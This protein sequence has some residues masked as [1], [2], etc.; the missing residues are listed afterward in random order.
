M[1]RLNRRSF[2]QLAGA[3]SISS[4]A[5]TA[6]AQSQP[7]V[8]AACAAPFP[9]GVHRWINTE[10]ESID[11]AVKSIHDMGLP[12]CQIGFERLTREAAPPS[13]LKNALAKYGVKAT[14]FTEHGPGVRVYDFYRGPETIGIVPP[15]T[16]Q[17]RIGNLKL[18][19]DIAS[20]CGIPAVHT[21]CGFI[22]EDPN[23]A[24]YPQAVAALKDIGSYCKKRGQIFLC[25][26][27]TETPITLLRLIEDT[28][29]DNVFVNLD[30]ADLIMWGKGNPVDAMDV[31]GHLVRGI[32]AKDGICPSNTKDHG[33]EVAMGEGKVDFPHV[34][35]KLRQANY[36]GAMTI[37]SEMP[38]ASALQQKASVLHSKAFLEHLFAKTC[39]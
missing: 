10:K 23:D 1:T 8:P 20:Q 15:A 39:G 26:T 7:R 13:A 38:G 17:A 3:A 11:D 16:R 37:E 28:G 27:A 32:H 18:A 34:L 4:G 9:L 22:P 12:T 33:G 30:T 35:Q 29:L 31:I 6:L 25:E 19:S 14:A 36:K 5:R 21:L 24:L 2:M